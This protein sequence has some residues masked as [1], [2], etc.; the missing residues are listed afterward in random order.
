MDMDT[1]V[2]ILRHQ[3]ENLQLEED[4]SDRR[5]V[6]MRAELELSEKRG[7]W[8]MAELTL[9]QE[10]A[11]KC[12]PAM[13]AEWMETLDQIRRSTQMRMQKEEDDSDINGERTRTC[14]EACGAYGFSERHAFRVHRLT[15]T[16]RV[17]LMG[18]EAEVIRMID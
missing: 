7:E 10:G 12:P 17:D 4:L 2:Q 6:A 14:A 5:Q 16:G 15:W 11:E 3:Q 13:K 8:S 1:I 18:G 9:V